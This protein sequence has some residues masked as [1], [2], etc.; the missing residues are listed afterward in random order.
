MLVAPLMITKQPTNQKRITALQEVM[1][2][3][4]AK[5][6]EVKYEWKHHKNIK[7]TKRR[8]SSF[9]ISEAIPSDEDQYYCVAMTDGGYAFSNNVTLTVDGEDDNCFVDLFLFVYGYTH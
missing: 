7:I 6:F 4:K 9:T 5:G 8:Q 2:T 1:F 3:C